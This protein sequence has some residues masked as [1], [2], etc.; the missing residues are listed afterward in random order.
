MTRKQ[1]DLRA[2]MAPATTTP[3]DVRADDEEVTA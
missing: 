1:T 3:A 2:L